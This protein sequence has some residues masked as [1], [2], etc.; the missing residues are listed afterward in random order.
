MNKLVLIVPIIIVAIFS[1]CSPSGKTGTANSMYETQKDTA[2]GLN[3][4]DISRFR[5]LDLN[6]KDMGAGQYK[7]YSNPHMVNEFL[8]LLSNQKY[9]VTGEKCDGYYKAELFDLNG[10]S[11]LQ[12]TFGS[13]SVNFDRDAVMGGNVVKKGTYEV[14]NWLDSYLKALYEGKVLDPGTIGYPSKLKLPDE[15]YS[16]QIVDK[17]SRKI[18]LYEVYPQLYDF[19]NNNFACKEFEITDSKRYYDRKSLEEVIS[20]TESAESCIELQYIGSETYLDI[21]SGNEYEEISKCFNIV[22]SKSSKG[23]DVYKLI[24]DNMVFYIRVKGEF[25]SLF[26]AVF[27]TNRSTSKVL[28]PDEIKK[29]FD[30]KKP[31]F[32]EYV[33]K[34]LGIDDFK[35]STPKSLEIKQMKLDN[36]A[37]LYTVL[38]VSNSFDVRLLI[39]KKDSANTRRFID[40]IDFG[41]HVAGTDYKIEKLGDEIFVTGNKC[42]G[43]GTGESKYCKEWY[44]V[45][46]QGKKLVLSFPYDDYSVAPWGGYSMHGDIKI[47]RDKETSISVNY[48]ITKMYLIDVDI[49]DKEGFIEIPEREKIVFQW[50][51]TKG[52]FKLECSVDEAGVTVIPVKSPNITQKC[53]GILEKYYEKLLKE[54]NSIPSGEQNELMRDAKIRGIKTFLDDCSD[55]EKK[56]DLSKRLKDIF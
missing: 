4:K 43:Y 51:K 52:I 23:P 1:S 5:V 44:T 25:D 20:K 29:L 47:N 17:G 7:E 38:S 21:E 36:K 16:L 3:L 35:G 30:E 19:V 55:S 12:V 8:N 26:Q 33:A 53:D 54:I 40:Y 2:A 13:M 49:A 15:S 10:K 37:D 9:T 42:K 45:N 32:M 56:T 31:Y 11:V 18:N 34:N 27:N 24:T 41:G 6:Q 50:D 48:S 14:E 46:D 22:L 28:T 39:F